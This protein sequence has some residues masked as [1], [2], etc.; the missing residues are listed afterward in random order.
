MKTKNRVWRS[1]IAFVL[2]LSMIVPSLSIP[3]KA[4]GNENL[5]LGKTATAS[6]SYPGKPWTPDKAVDGDTKGSD[7]RWSSKRATGTTNEGDGDIGTKEQWLMVDLGAQTPVN[8]INIYWEAAFATKYEIQTSL[9]GQEFTTVKECT[10]TE[11]GSQTYRDLQVD[12]ARYVRIYCQEPKTAKYGYS[13]Y[14]LEVFA[15]N[16]M[17]SAKDVLDSLNGQKPEISDDGTHLVLPEVPDGYQISLYGSDNQQV[18]KLDGTIIQPLVDMDVNLL[19]KVENAEDAEDV[20]KSEADIKIT[21]PGK[22]ETE[23]RDNEKPNV[24]PG[25]REW[26]GGEGTYTRT[27]DTRLVVSDDSMSSAADVIKTYFD[28]MLDIDIEIVKGEEPKAGDVYLKTGGTVDELGEEGYLLEIG[29]YVT[30]TSPTVTG[31]TYGGASVTQILYQDE[32]MDNIAKGTARDYPKYPIRAGMV[33]VGRMYIPLEYLKEMTIYM[34]WFKMNEIQVHINDYW[35]QSGYSAFRLESDTYPEIVADDGYYTKDDYRQYQKDMK[36]YGIDVITEIDTPYHAE[37]FRDV[38]G[39]KMLDGKKGYL[40]ITTD[41]AREAN[42]EIIENLIDE[43]LDGEDPVV[44][45]ENFHIGTDE[46]DKKYGE[47]M[48][49]WTDHFINYVNDKGYKTRLWGSLGKN[50]FNGTTPVSN[51][52]VMNMWAP[53]WADVHEMYDAGYDMINTYGG[54]LYIVPSGNAGYPDRLDLKRLYNEFEVNNYKSGRNPSGEAIMPIAHPQTKGAEFCVWNDMTSFKTGF[55]WFDIFDRFKEGVAIV[56][57]KTWFGEKQ[58]GQ[59]YEEFMARMDALDDKVPNANPGRHV[60]SVDSKVAEYKFSQDGTDTSENGYDATLHG[61]VVEDGVVKTEK[62]G[63]ISL[64]FDSMGYPYTV[65]AKVNLSEIDENTTIFKGKDGV[66]YADIDGSGKIGF[67]RGAYR[68]SFDYELPENEWVTLTFVGDTKNTTLYVNGVNK[69]TAKTMDPT[70]AGKTQQSGTSVMTFEKILDQAKGSMDNLEIYN[71]AMSESEIG[72]ALNM[73]SRDNLALNKEVSVSGLEV[74]DGRFTADKAVDGVVSSDSRVSFA[75]TADEQW[76]LVDLGEVKEISEFV[77]NYESQVPK[78]KIQVS[79]DGETYTDVYTF[80]DNTFAESSKGIPGIQNVKVDPVKARYVKYVQ[81][82]RWHHTGNGNYYSGSLYE[83]EVYASLKD[84]LKEYAQAALDELGKY[85]A[86]TG[87]GDVEEE[88][89]NTFKEELERYISL[90]EGTDALTEEDFMTFKQ[91]ILDKQDELADHILVVAQE[92]IDAYNEAM[93]LKE[94]DYTPESWAKFQE[95]MAKISLDNL[96]TVEEVDA[97][98]AA[99]NDAMAVLEKVQQQDISTAVLEYA[100]E[101]AGKADTEGIIPVIAKEFETRLADAQAILE[102]VD[103][104]DKT[105]TQEMVDDSWKA[106]IDIMQFLEFKQGDK[107]DLEKVIAFA[108]SLDMND[109]E[110]NEKMDAFL[111]VL[112]EAKKVRDDENAMQKEI[113][114]AWMKLLKATAELNRKMADKTDLNKVIEWSSALDL[115]KYLEEGQDTFR[116][117]L[118]NAKTVADDILATQKEVDDSWKALMDAAS[119][120]RLKPD[121]GALEEL[122][123]QAE[124]FHEADYD[125]A[126][127]AAFRSAVA[128]AQAVYENEQAT[129]DEVKAAEESLKGAIAKLTSATDGSKDAGKGVTANAA[130]NNTGTSKVKDSEK[131]GAETGN[132]TARSAKT[133]DGTPVMLLVVL[134]AGAALVAADRRRRI[135]R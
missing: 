17:G 37:C 109:Y 92:A 40:D 63:Y 25:L 66:V 33:D 8:Q 75:K 93:A 78:Y 54:W 31:M 38:P 30:I 111:S 106:L 2:T 134:M 70:I 85:T 86:G 116:T 99:V 10:A 79:E 65:F 132:S 28:D 58:D 16:S 90:A 105:V 11:A 36:K 118:E 81:E 27:A 51:E 68:F 83:F 19:Y 115:S 104:G 94:S 122:L 9:N 26:K 14:E 15:Q 88:F 121:K 20:A 62:D 128:Q 123:N 43:Y 35:S 57:E 52:A 22:Y 113:D 77:L 67:K 50:G 5:A 129:L 49:K 126:S 119:A 76:L 46:Y 120:L 6:S 23:N 107:T 72:D 18:V 47:Q 87:N 102:R 55:S 3:A 41:E 89:Y 80:E 95:M 82:K 112:D 45:S 127:F 131:T 42:Q 39:V 96:N 73:A 117:A 48:R 84:E 103:S 44:Q 69:G 12:A 114:D 1:L 7:S 101:L 130:G 91:N 24:L 53:Y 74:N 108:E 124:G 59:T 98:V 21:V 13:I 4:A 100:I 133:G 97:V 60:D 71:Y 125:K 64:P 32:N 135:H 110:D 61:A 56:S 29:D 34:S